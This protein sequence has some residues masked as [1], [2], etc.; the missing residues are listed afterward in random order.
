MGAAGTEGFG[1]ALCRANAEDTGED[2]GIRNGDGET[3]HYETDAH[4]NE[5]HQL[6]DVGACA[7]KLEERRYVTHIMVDDV[8]ITEAESQHAPSVGHS[9]H[10]PHHICTHC[11]H[12]ADLMGHGHLV[13]KGLTDGHISVI[14]H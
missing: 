9:T 11:Q 4:Y 3:G 5:N 7:G 8:A 1:P 6:I 10:Q 13:Q 12:E 2:Q 14:G